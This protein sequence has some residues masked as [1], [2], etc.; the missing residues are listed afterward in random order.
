MTDPLGETYK[1]FA[2]PL[3]TTGHTSGDDGL[4]LGPGAA[5]AP[6]QARRGVSRNMLVGGVAGAAVLGL[7][8]GVFA[9][10]E[11]AH[12]P[13]REPMQPVTASAE[14]GATPVPVEVAAVTPPPLPEPAGKLEVLPPDLARAA[15]AQAP[16]ARRTPTQTTPPPPQRDAGEDEAAPIRELAPPPMARAARPSFDCGRAGSRAERMICDDAVLARLDR[17][18]DRAFDRAVASGIPYRE[19]RAEQDD[20]LAVREDA[21]RRSPDAVES[22]YRQRIA[23]LDDLGR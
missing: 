8:F 1:G 21:A 12:A 14:A 5:K 10:P 17:R 4:R 16:V 7:L 15:R 23:E 20:W 18:L 2:G 3:P 13:S 19:L 9:R 22:V 6:P 11:L